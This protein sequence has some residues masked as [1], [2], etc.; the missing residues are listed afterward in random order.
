MYIHIYETFHVSPHGM[1]HFMTEM[2]HASIAAKR[3]LWL[4]LIKSFA[5]SII[6]PAGWTLRDVV[7]AHN[8]FICL[9][10]ARR[11]QSDD[12]SHIVEATAH[13][14]TNL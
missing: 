7:Q 10:L 1:K 4:M 13:C 9:G 12:I 14:T 2:F 3:I 6:I 8:L 5:N 11:P